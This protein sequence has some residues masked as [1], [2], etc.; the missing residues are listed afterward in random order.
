VCLLNAFK[1]I[2]YR[3]RN[4]IRLSAIGLLASFGLPVKRRGEVVQSRTGP[5]LQGFKRER[6][7]RVL[8]LAMSHLG[9]KTS[10]N[11]IK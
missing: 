1:G 7:I 10:V 11:V 6:S 9:S 2:S 5:P 4:C 8:L 3:L